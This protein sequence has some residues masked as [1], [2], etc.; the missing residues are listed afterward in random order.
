MS[1]PKKMILEFPSL[2]AREDYI[3]K[4]KLSKFHRYKRV[5]WLAVEIDENE[6]AAMKKEEGVEVFEDLTFQPVLGG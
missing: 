5:P 6:I 2:R 1:S 3:A 4:A